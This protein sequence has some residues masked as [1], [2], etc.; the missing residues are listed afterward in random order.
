VKPAASHSRKPTETPSGVELPLHPDEPWSLEFGPAEFDPQKFQ[1]QWLV[2][3]K[4]PWWSGKH[5]K[6]LWKIT[7]FNG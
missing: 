5:T 1:L 3:G 6:N 7:I 2:T 4:D